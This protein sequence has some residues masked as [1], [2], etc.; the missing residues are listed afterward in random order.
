V[1]CDAGFVEGSVRELRERFEERDQR[2]KVTEAS[3]NLRCLDRGRIER[4]EFVDAEP[5][6]GMVAEIFLGR[7]EEDA[8]GP[9]KRLDR[10][11]HAQGVTLA[12][13]RCSVIVCNDPDVKAREL[14]IVGLEPHALA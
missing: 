12:R 3:A 2:D 7:A 6:I 9:H 14:V 8:N 10:C 13:V 1:E 4:H 11:G 5:C